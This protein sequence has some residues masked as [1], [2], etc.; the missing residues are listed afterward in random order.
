ME[1]TRRDLAFLAEVDMLKVP[2]G[3]AETG[4]L[5][6]EQARR[7]VDAD[8]DICEL[9]SDYHQAATYYAEVVAA[10]AVQTVE[11]E[12]VLNSAEVALSFESASS[13]GEFPTFDR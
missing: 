1:L 13:A 11:A 7:A 3:T 8:P 12:P 9:L 10:M 6:V 2:L 4:M 5:T